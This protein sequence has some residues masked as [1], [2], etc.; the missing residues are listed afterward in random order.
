MK[1]KRIADPDLIPTHLVEQIPDQKG[2]A[3]RFYHIM[4]LMIQSPTHFLYVLL[5]DDNTIVGYLWFEVN[6]LDHVVFI[7]TL[8]VDEKIWGDKGALKLAVEFVK[9]QMASL[10]ISKAYLMT[11]RPKGFESLGFA[12]SNNYLLEY[13]LTDKENTI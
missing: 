9:S 4:G 5:D 10:G 7:N 12:K 11:D 2:H 1:F 13:H 6:A 3:N 8:S